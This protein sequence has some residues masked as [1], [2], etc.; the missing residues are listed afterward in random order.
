MRAE[1]VRTA[2]A[3][4]RATKAGVTATATRRMAARATSNPIRATA[5]PAETLVT[6]PPVNRALPG[7]ASSSRASRKKGPRIERSTPDCLHDGG[8]VRR[9]I[10]V[11]RRLRDQ[12]RHA[13]RR[14]R[15]QRRG[16]FARRRRRGLD[17]WR[18]AG[19][20]AVPC[21]SGAF[22]PSE[23]FGPQKP[24]GSLDSRARIVM[25]RGRLPSDAWA[26]GARGTILHFDGT[27]WK[28]SD[29]GTDNTINAI[30]AT[31]HGGGRLEHADNLGLH[32]RHRARRLRHESAPSAGGWTARAI[33]RL[34]IAARGCSRRPGRRRPPS[35][36]GARRWRSPVGFRSTVSGVFASA[37]DEHPRSSGGGGSFGRVPRA[38][39]SPP[40]EHPRRDGER[41]LWAWVGLTGATV[42]ITNAR[43]GIAE[44]TPF[45]SQT[46]ADL[47]GVLGC[48]AD[49]RVGGRSNGRNFH[50]TGVR[51][52][53][54]VAS[55][56]CPRK[57]PFAAYGGRHRRTSGPSATSPSTR[58]TTAPRPRCRSRAW[59]RASSVPSTPCGRPR[60]GM[61][62]QPVTASFF[63][64]EASHRIHR[65]RPR[66]PDGASRVN[67]LSS[68]SRACRFTAA[69]VA[70]A[71][72]GN[73]DAT[74]RG[75]RLRQT[76]YEGGRQPMAGR[77][78][79]QRPT[80]LSA[81]AT[82]S[83]AGWCLTA[84]PKLSRRAPARCIWP[85]PTAIRHR[86]DAV[87]AA[88]DFLRVE[89]RQQSMVRHRR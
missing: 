34:N 82:C 10:V 53:R 78:V 29:P 37:V 13:R 81:S 19:R 50:Y 2:R 66:Q 1:S 20:R 47:H 76:L 56:T 62:G 79:K 31:R 15:R 70:C 21:P 25:I 87:S 32:P 24:A 54:G 75:A 7:G 74:P 69:A 84:L 61:S 16:P 14:A 67:S 22:C 8:G 80:M 35:G 85:L 27:S 30:P 73:D 44:I 28:R 55:R 86:G 36:C 3:H 42:H 59:K 63:R 48:F 39:L 64:L 18:R 26:V 68:A 58:T 12:R 49:L 4:S 46:W 88:A 65:T 51:P 5:G 33:P 9:S 40:G 72:S 6:W 77:F 41:F 17:R 71:A 83:A 38:W 57:R 52:L 43:R 89:R 45:D 11:P 23:S 60:R